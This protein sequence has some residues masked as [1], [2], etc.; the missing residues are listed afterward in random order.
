M[1]ISDFKDQRILILGFAREGQDTL[2]FLRRLFPKQVV[3]VAD[4]NAK[5]PRKGKNLRYYL[6]K[7][8]LKKI[9]DYDIIIKTPGIPPRVLRPHLKKGQK[10][11][12]QTEIFL[13]NCPGQIIGVT[14]SKG[15]STTTSLIYEVLRAGGLKAHLVGNIGQPVLS[16]LARAKAADVFVCEFS[17]HQ[18][19][20]LKQSPHIAVFL[21]FYP[22]HLDYYRNLAEYLRAKQN[23]CRW[24]KREDRFLFNPQDPKVRSCL[25]LTIAKKIPLDV[26]MAERFLARWGS[27]KLAGFYALNMAAAIT[28]GR[29]F[30]IPDQKIARAIRAFKPLPHRLE[31]V[32]EY[33]GIRF[34]NDSLA[35]IPEATIAGLGALGPDVQTIFLGGF[36]RGVSFQQLAKV[37]LA[38]Q[39]DNL[40]FFP[41]SGQRIWQAILAQP[42]SQKRFFNHFFVDKM[43]EAVQIAFEK[44]DRDRICLL[45]CA[46]PSFGL[47]KD[48]RERG[49]LFKKLVRQLGRSHQ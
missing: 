29:L 25:K 40:I 9:G 45:S 1:E 3:D 46:S 5:I 35:T 20:N 38:S 22:E 14:G 21:N 43:K 8:Y 48:Y 33:R 4:Q 26:K 39:I 42:G 15:K 27:A 10:I 31:P 16:F 49:D 47:F 7:N 34:Y 30:K 13:A 28:V 36:D 32:G 2:R 24:Q 12:S 23:I 44:T 17:S 11:T 18:L 41:P 19:M 37:I 6:G